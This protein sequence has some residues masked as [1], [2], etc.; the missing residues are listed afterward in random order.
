MAETK[1]DWAAYYA[2]AY[3]HHDEMAG[4]ARKYGLKDTAEYFEERARGCRSK[5]E[6]KGILSEFYDELR[7]IKEERTWNQ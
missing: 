7:D 5:A 3:I 1:T 6:K 4:M 2:A